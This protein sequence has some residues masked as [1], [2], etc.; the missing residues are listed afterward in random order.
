MRS[1]EATE[2]R[3][4]PK[5]S[6]LPIC[7]SFA[8][9]Y[10]Y[11]YSVFIGN[12]SPS[13]LPPTL[14]P[15]MSRF[16][17]DLKARY[18]RTHILRDKWPPTP[19]KE[20]IKLASVEKTGECRDDFIGH[21]LQGDIAHVARTKL[22]EE[23]VLDLCAGECRGKVV[24]IEG[25]PGIGKSTLAWE[26]CRKWEDRAS[27]KVFSLV[28][29]LR[30]REERVQDI[31]D[32]SSLFYAYRRS[33][34]MSLVDE[35]LD[36]QGKDV[37]FVLDGYDELPK[38]LQ[39][40]G[41]LVDLLQ[42][43]ILPDSTVI[44]TSRPSASGNLLTI[45]EAAKRIEILGFTQ[46]SIQSY[47][48]S[49]FSNSEE[50]KGFLKYIAA[51]DNPAINSLMYV[52]LYAAFIVIIY[53]D[54]KSDDLLPHTL[55]EL[56]TQLCL[57][58]LNRY[59]PTKNYPTVRKIEDLPTE[60]YQQFLKL[61]KFAFEGFKNEK[62]IFRENIAEHFGFLDAVPE[63][64]GGCAVSFN[65]LHLTL[66][67]F[68]AAYHIS[69]S[70]NVK[71]FR[72]PYW[73]VVW[74]FVAGLT[75]FR[76]LQTCSEL[77]TEDK[78]DM[79]FVQCLFEAHDIKVDF[80]STFNSKEVTEMAVKSQYG[81]A[82]LDYYALGY[83]VANC[84]TPKSAWKVDTTPDKLKMFCRGLMTNKSSTGVIRTL[85]LDA[86]KLSIAI[87]DLI[88]FMHRVPK[89]PLSHIVNLK[90]C[91]ALVVES[92]Y[93]GIIS[94]LPFLQTLD[95]SGC[96]L[97]YRDPQ[98]SLKLFWQLACS[99]VNTLNISR[100][101]FEENLGESPLARDCHAAFQDMIKPSGNL[102]EL[103][104]EFSGISNHACREEMIRLISAPSSLEVLTILG[105]GYQLSNFAACNNL[106]EVSIDSKIIAML[107]HTLAPDLVRI[108]NC[109]RTLQT[110]RLGLFSIGR[111]FNLQRNI[112]LLCDKGII[113]AL[114]RNS[115][116]KHFVIVLNRQPPEYSPD[117]IRALDSRIVIQWLV[118]IS[119]CVKNVVPCHNPRTFLK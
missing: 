118:L 25:A 80:G 32:D 54:S 72:K 37:L 111:L 112:Q 116:L 8:C 22:T 60:L 65:F 31:N 114:Q 3:E 84:T 55:T 10:F 41:V 40:E 56:Y 50:L 100:T 78:V 36:S 7:S 18:K 14:S 6:P 71:F 76:F 90:I 16:A 26:L 39:R 117:S 48:V 95:L 12:P 44:V 105:E 62:V 97:H 57:T 42:R 79:L 9:K 33:D 73:E 24:M 89:S 74:R 52:P 23:D 21:V 5:V 85:H 30:L 68:F 81:L 96:N 106:T 27:M 103:T 75:K 83:C 119:C 11:C 29:L 64:Y 107:L 113:T 87:A 91:D 69:K 38:S 99:K 77:L 101:K 93:A 15:A 98:H 63:L 82:D 4:A 92:Y 70:S 110:L 19:S 109:S 28:I 59:L 17:A 2:I 43:S 104:I 45:C 66:Q 94:H 49:M 86:E 1:R 108:I 53:K 35:I 115:T 46:E 20:Y 51:S 34:R 58:I 13:A 61:A 67:E 47:A 88:S 102:K